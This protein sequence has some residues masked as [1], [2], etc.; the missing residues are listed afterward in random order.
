MA[1]VFLELGA[2][3]IGLALLAR[4]AARVGISPIPLYLLGGLVFGTGGIL[5]VVF[6]AE[7]IQVGAEIG[8]ILLLFMLGL[9]YT[10][11]ELQSSLRT[12]LP[13]G[14]VDLGLNFSPGLVAGLLLG[15]HPL[16]ALLLGGVTYISSSG[17]I[18]KL[19]GDLN[20]LGNRETP[21]VLAILVLEDL[22]MAIYLPLLAVLLIGNELTVGLLSLVV[23]VTTVVVVLFLA[24]RY[25]QTMSRIVASRSNEVVLLTTFGL[26][27]L[28]AGAA[29]WL[30]VS[31]A[32][33]AF[34]VGVAL[35]G[36]VAEQARALLTPLRDL[37]AA[38]FFL[39]FGLQ[40][41]PTSIPPVLLL[42]IGI[43]LITALT[44][45]ATGWWAARRIGVASRGRFRAGSTLVARGEFS[46]VIAGLGVTANLEPDLGPLAAA[47]VLFLAVA[48]PMLAR[49]IDPLVATVER[50]R[51]A[52]MLEH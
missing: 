24:M 8:V 2:M 11:E 45:I 50:R 4:L 52:P 40:T 30:Q 49:V 7:F 29:Q 38:T 21:V 27:L 9:E 28:V 20:W 19:L 43:G 22:A 26:V 47:Y 3:I 37:F 12:G 44:K 33:G 15:W 23:A 39:F 14:L 17:V 36:P 34:L 16:A 31:A 48:G 10:G 35:S 46:I 41:D 13:A 51:A 25:G 32:V 18:A 6:S 5:P 42:A 1:P